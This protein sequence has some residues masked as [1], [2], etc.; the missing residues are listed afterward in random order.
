MENQ[1]LAKSSLERYRRT[2]ESAKGD[3]SEQI[4]DTIDSKLRQVIHEWLDVYSDEPN[5]KVFKELCKL[6]DKK[7]LFD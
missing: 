2:D 7:S 1:V 4:L 5:S 6:S 3:M